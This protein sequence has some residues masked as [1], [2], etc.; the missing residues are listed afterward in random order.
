MQA[1]KQKYHIYFSKGL[2]KSD[3]LDKKQNPLVYNYYL[4][5]LDYQLMKVASKIEMTNKTRLNNK[6]FR[7]SVSLR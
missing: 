5:S 1:K 3:L 6:F 2:V 4:K 7:R